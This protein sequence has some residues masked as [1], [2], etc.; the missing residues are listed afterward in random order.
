[1]PRR[2][3]E[4]FLVTTRDDLLTLYRRYQMLPIG[5]QVPGTV[6]VEAE[7]RSDLL[8]FCSELAVE[9]LQPYFAKHVECA[10]FRFER[11]AHPGSTTRRAKLL[12]LVVERPLH[13]PADRA[14]DVGARRRRG[15][16]THAYILRRF[17][18]VPGSAVVP[19][20]AVAPCVRQLRRRAPT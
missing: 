4:W 18:C 7:N 10:G 16:H 9:W 15:G 5:Y 17:R 8:R 19:P 14:A 1:M 11:T 6:R 20:R 12:I 2:K 13:L 3:K